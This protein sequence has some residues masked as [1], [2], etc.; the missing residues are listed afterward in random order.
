MVLSF[1]SALSTVPQQERLN[2]TKRSVTTAIYLKAGQNDLHAADASIKGSG[3]YN[4]EEK[5]CK[6]QLIR[7]GKN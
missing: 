2:V 1:P 5:Y 3:S 4:L 7:A 6:I